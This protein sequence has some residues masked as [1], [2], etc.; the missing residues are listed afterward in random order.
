M[1]PEDETLSGSDKD[2]CPRAEFVVN[3]K[4]KKRRMATA[5]RLVWP[6]KKSP[7][8]IIIMGLLKE[9]Y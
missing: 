9:V 1:E 4:H 5:A 6:K 8:V 3:G 2:L 7:N